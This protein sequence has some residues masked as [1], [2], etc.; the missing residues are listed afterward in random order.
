MPPVL[1]IETANGASVEDL[2]QRA[3]DWLVMIEKQYKV[4]PIIY[5]N[6]DFY[7]NFFSR[8]V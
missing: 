3:K 4:R 7:N 5:T 8:Q 1:D 6:V 2:Q